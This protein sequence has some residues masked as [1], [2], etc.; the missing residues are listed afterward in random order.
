MLEHWTHGILSMER[1]FLGVGVGGICM[2]FYTHLQC[3]S[4]VFV[5]WRC[6]SVTLHIVGNYSFFRARLLP[7]ENLSNTDTD[8]GL[9]FV[10]TAQISNSEPTNELTAY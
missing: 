4:S 6:T 2:S 10:C 7:Y 9:L 3:D 5:Y 1:Y 8:C